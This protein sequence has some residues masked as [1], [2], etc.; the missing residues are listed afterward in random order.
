[1]TKLPL[2]LEGR[3]DLI[4]YL[5][6]GIYF[7]SSGQITSSGW[8]DAR[9]LELCTRLHRRTGFGVYSLGYDIRSAFSVPLLFYKPNNWINRVYDFAR[10]KEYERVH[11]IGFSGGGSVASSQT[12]YYSDPI[13]KNLIIISGMVGH[14]PKAAH[15]NAAFWSNQILPPTLLIYGRD[16]GLYSGAVEWLKHNPETKLIPYNGGHDYQPVMSQV[17]DA[18]VA[19]ISPDSSP[20]PPPPTG[21][22][23]IVKV[24]V[25]AIPLEVTLREN[26]TETITITA[27]P[28]I[29]E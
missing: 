4:C 9:D 18:I 17:E 1:M 15:V 24:T 16:D 6:G 8:V 14:N 7:G 25:G 22:K 26:Q 2:Y 29:E 21:R 13:V 23:I 19:Q 12:L 3:D 28:R 10:T 11:L 5:P 20:P 27:T